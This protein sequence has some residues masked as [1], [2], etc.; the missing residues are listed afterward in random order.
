MIK[1]QK[2]GFLSSFSAIHHGPWYKNDGL[3]ETVTIKD[4]D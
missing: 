1:K 2:K 3:I 4:E